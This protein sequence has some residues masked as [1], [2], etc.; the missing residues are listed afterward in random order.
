[1]K[2]FS[3]QCYSICDL[4]LS[5]C[6]TPTAF[7]NEC[8]ALCVVL[9]IK[10]VSTL[11]TALLIPAQHSLV[12]LLIL[13]LLVVTSSCWLPKP[14]PYYSQVRLPP[15]FGCGH[16]WMHAGFGRPLREDAWASSTRQLWDGTVDGWW[17]GSE[18]AG[19]LSS[20]I[21]DVSACDSPA[22]YTDGLSRVC[23]LSAVGAASP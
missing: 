16:A 14:K 2:T 7:Y 6:T 13:W 17:L 9:Y 5:S 10:R 22:Y 11:V 3:Q 15:L 1:M 19:I 8:F 4:S 21:M 18:R 20:A 23:T 12:R